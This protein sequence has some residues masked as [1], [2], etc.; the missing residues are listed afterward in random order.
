[1]DVFGVKEWGLV[2][3]KGKVNGLGSKI[4]GGIKDE[5][6]RAWDR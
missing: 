3:D 6:R 1:M 5:V 2:H 4:T